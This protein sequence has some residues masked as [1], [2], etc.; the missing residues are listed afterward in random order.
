MD[1]MVEV[2]IQLITTDNTVRTYTPLL[3]FSSPVGHISGKIEEIN[4]IKNPYG[5]K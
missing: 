4:S 3:F 5:S 2:R 1:S